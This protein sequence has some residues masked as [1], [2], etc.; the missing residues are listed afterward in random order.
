M[1]LGVII[2]LAAF[3]LQFNSSSGVQFVIKTMNDE[4][5]KEVPLWEQQWS[6]TKSMLPAVINTWAF[7]NATNRAW[8]VLYKNGKSALDAVEQ[9]C[10]VCENEQCDGTVG[11]G[12]S[13]DEN[14][15]TTLDAMIMDGPTHRCGA[16]ASMK[17]IKSA[18]SVARKVMEHTD[19]TLLVGEGATQFAVEMGFPYE[20]LTTNE[21]SEIWQE[22]KNRNCQ[23]NFW[24]NVLPIPERSCGPYTPYEVQKE[25]EF[26]TKDEPKKSHDTIGMVAID[27]DGKMASGT[28][29]NGARHKIPGRVGDAPIIG[30]GSY[31]DQEI[32]GAAATGDGDVLMRF[33][34]SFATVEHMRSGMTP[35]TAAAY[36]LKRIANYYPRFEGAVVAMRKNGEFG[37]ACHGF[38]NF[39]YA[40]SNPDLEQPRV[41][42]VDCVLT[43]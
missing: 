30:S 33:L 39:T 36:S 17:N 3:F 20:N 41:F 11:F 12:G 43:E 38:K 22:W 24:M 8:E 16:V 21:S 14:G 9:G 28:S 40:V 5:G 32:G 13:P 19:H 23:P 29:T 37:A 18:I 31:V 34:P 15:E 6:S 35:S 2:G 4:I 25:T 27:V 7:T 26:G 10:S 42:F 1:L